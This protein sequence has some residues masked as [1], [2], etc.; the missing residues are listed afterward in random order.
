LFTVYLSYAAT[1]Q[2]RFRLDSLPK[3]E[4]EH[5]WAGTWL[6]KDPKRVASF[7]TWLPVWIFLGMTIGFGFL[8]HGWAYHKPKPKITWS[9]DGE[10]V[11][12]APT[13]TSLR[14]KCE[15]QGPCP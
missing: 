13:N 10:K 4:I 5:D 14:L 9:F 2:K 12:N 11:R 6:G 3:R 8:L 1:E 15:G 7:G